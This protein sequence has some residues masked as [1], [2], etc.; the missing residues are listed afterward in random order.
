VALY[1]LARGQEWFIAGDDLPYTGNRRYGWIDNQTAYVYGENPGGYDQPSRVYDVQYDASGLPACLVSAFPDAVTRFAD[2]WERQNSRLSL[3]GLNLLARTVCASLPNTV[4]GI[5]NILEPPPA[6]YVP[7]ATTTPALVAGVPACLTTNFPDRAL[8]YAQDWRKITQGLSP[9]DMAK[10][11]QYLCESLRGGGDVNAPTPSVNG[12]TMLIDVNTG[13][14]STGSFNFPAADER[15]LGPLQDAFLKVEKR[16]LGNAALSPDEQ[17]L[18]EQ[19]SDGLLTIYRVVVPYRQLLSTLT[20]T[21]NQYATAQNIIGV[22]PSPTPTFDALGTPRPT[23]TATVTPTSPPVPQAT[24]VQSG[25]DTQVLCPATALYR[26]ENLPPAY[27]PAGVITGTVQ[28]RGLW[29]MQP[30][31]GYSYAAPEIPQ[32]GVGMAC[33]YSPDFQWILTQNADGIALMRPDGRDYRILFHVAEQTVWP[34]DL[35]WY[36]PDVLQYTTTREVAHDPVYEITEVH[37]IDVNTGKDTVRADWPPVAVNQLPTE[38]VSQQPGGS[39]AIVR[40]SFNTGFGT[41]YKYYTYNRVSG[42]WAYF[43]RTSATDPQGPFGFTWS[44]LG[45]KL[46]YQQKTLRKSDDQVGTATGTLFAPQATPTMGPLP[47]LSPDGQP[48]PSPFADN[49]VVT[50]PWYTFNPAT[51]EHAYLGSF[52]NGTWSQDGRYTAFSLPQPDKTSSQ[53]AI[54]DSQSGNTQKYCLPE[55]GSGGYGGPILWSPDSRYLALV[56][57]L[58]R[59]QQEI[60]PHLLIL[61]LATGT[62]TDLGIDFKQPIFWIDHEAMR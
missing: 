46:Y 45:D 60:G 4:D 8:E 22:R 29:V 49:T 7:Q 5:M 41:G 31:D 13:V 12:L 16:E 32:C 30:R 18:A 58:P 35:A 9:E 43:A 20:A 59:D 25:A 23:M 54:W 27:S 52:P 21:A 11:E 37:Q 17:Y 39:L 48:T 50:S 6:T 44:P 3:N 62:T 28:G 26:I 24:A 38:L 1:S 42:S 36:A 15:P 2:V 14:R 55:T 51:G 10:M 40:I 61:D 53:I 19:N 47:T 33:Q 56:A 57:K 34:R